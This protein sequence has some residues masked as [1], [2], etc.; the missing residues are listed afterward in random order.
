MK[1]KNN[2][3]IYLLVVVAALVIFNQ[4]QIYSIGAVTGTG[5]AIKSTSGKTNLFSGKELSSINIDELKSTGHSVAALFPV[6]DI[7]TA[8]DAVDIIIPKGTPEYGAEMGVSFDEPVKAL[9]D[10]S[11]AQ[12]PLLASLTPEEK[13]RFLSIAG[14][15]VGLSCEY[16]CGVGPIG[17]DKNGN[18]ACGCQHNPAILA[19]TMWLIKN[20]PTMSD[21]EIIREGLKWKALFF[22]KDMVNLAMK[23]AGGDTSSLK[24]LPGM[25]GGC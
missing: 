22:P 5:L 23:V 17:I 12:R 20:R 13:E 6:E 7:K 24:D 11:K 1:E 9:A 4:Y 16:C 25:V 21:A 18:S 10:L 3:S 8:Q 2:L 14:K 15:P 19:V